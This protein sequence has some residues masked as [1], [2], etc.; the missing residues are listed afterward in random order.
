MMP[1]ERDDAAPRQMIYEMRR[2]VQ[3]ARNHYWS[4]GVDGEI[5]NEVHRELAVAVLQYHDVLLEFRDES[6]LDKTDF[7]NI[8][9]L[10]DKVARRVYATVPS[11]G[12]GRGSEVDEV[13]AVTTV[14][15]DEILEMSEQLDDLCKKLGFGAKA[16]EK[17]EHNDIGHDDLAHLLEQRGQDEALEKVP[18]DAE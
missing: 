18:G 9:K 5:S 16:K 17:T 6:V 10:R 4:E 8:N 12:R 3:R 7:P 13:P 2:R 1:D 14:P 15:V 11:G